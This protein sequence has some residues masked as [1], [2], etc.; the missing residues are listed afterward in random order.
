MTK[1]YSM[2]ELTPK[3]ECIVPEISTC[4]PLPREFFGLPFPPQVPLKIPVLIHTLLKTLLLMRP[5]LGNSNNASWDGYGYFLK[6]LDS[7]I[8]DHL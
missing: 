5:S 4:I 1:S 7:K 6:P 2:R 3:P 8:P